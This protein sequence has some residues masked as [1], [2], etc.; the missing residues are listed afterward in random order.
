MKYLKAY[1][2]FE[3]SNIDEILDLFI[4]LKDKGYIISTT[5]PYKPGSM[6]KWDKYVR[7][8]KKGKFELDDIKNDLIE[9]INYMINYFNIR[10]VEIQVSNDSNYEHYI[11]IQELIMDH[12]FNLTCG[13]PTILS[14]INIYFK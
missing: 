6:S 5:A 2:I 3:N 12:E 1:Q 7:I 4:P 9:I 11:D 14:T 10:I 8:S 13:D